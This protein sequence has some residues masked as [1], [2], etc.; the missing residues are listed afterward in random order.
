MPANRP[1]K[2]ERRDAKLDA[3]KT[4]PHSIEAEQSVLGGLMLDNQAW[5]TIAGEL[6]GDDF[7]HRGHRLIFQAMHHLSERN[8]PIDLVTVSET[9][10]T[11]GELQDVGGF[12]YLGEIAK[13]TPSA[14]NIRAYAQIVR[15]RAVVREMIAVAN[16]IAESGFD[17]QNRTSSELLDLAESKVFKI[18]EKRTNENE[19]PQAIA[20]ILQRTVDRIDQLSRSKNPNGI[21]GISSG[22][23]DLD[24]MTSGLQPADL[25]IVAARPS[26]GK[27]TFAMNLCENVALKNDKPVLVFSLEMPSEQIMMRML[28]SLSHVDQTRIRNGQLKDEDW[29]RIASTINI[30]KERNNIFIDDSSGLTPTEVR[31]RARRVFR[32]SGGL[33]MI[34]VD[35]LQLMTVPGNNENRTLEIAEISR[36]LKSLAKELSIPVVALSQLNRSLEQRSNRRPINSDLRESGSIEQDADVIMFIYRDEVY[37]PETDEQGVAEVIIGKQRN[38]PIGTVK[39]KFQGSLS[40][41]DNLALSEPDGH[42]GY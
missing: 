23:Y 39:L 34:M 14:A 28:A 35:Y 20:P 24:R 5:D 11:T 13:N 37:N 4:P 3:I 17:T 30:L 32:E 15:E 36:S 18:A 38:G 40:R 33:S 26:M 41:F 31:S 27:T 29:T 25:I 8:L 16:E 2:Q 42:S 12:A 22:F 7:Y 19:G 1:E 21:T 6:I 9:L 10:E